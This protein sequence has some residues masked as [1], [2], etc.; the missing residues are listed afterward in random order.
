MW[1]RLRVS[2]VSK[3]PTHVRQ[4]EVHPQFRRVHPHP[5]RDFTVSRTKVLVDDLNRRVS[6]V[7]HG[8]H[9][10][11]YGRQNSPHTG[12]VLDGDLD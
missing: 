1:T 10:K 2:A 6:V 4:P 11:R 7:D 9:L 5:P 8:G 3:N 12:R